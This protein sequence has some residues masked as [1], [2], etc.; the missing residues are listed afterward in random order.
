MKKVLILFMCFFLTATSVFAKADGE[1]VKVFSTYALT[2]DVNPDWQ[3]G[4]E[5]E[6]RWGDDVS[7]F[8]YTH[9]EA[10]LAYKG[11]AKWLQL[12]VGYRQIFAEG[13]RNF[14][15][16]NMPLAYAT[17]K[18]DWKGW[19]I[20]DRNRMEY[21]DKE[22]DNDGWRYRNKV[23]IATPWKFTKY[24][25]RPYVA[26]EIFFDCDEYDITKNRVFGG[27]MFNIVEHVSGEF[28]YLWEASDK[29]KW[30]DDHIIG[31]KIK[32]SF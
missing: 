13:S 7:N 26:E 24:E 32:F 23:T 8:Y 25:I 31:N 19:T 17:V 27:L 20:S 11:I 9:T 14:K 10:T 2:Y 16:E 30:F 18:G 3:L 5:E 29:G 22:D 28:Y 1:D 12:G 4:L 15:Y 6:L 21:R